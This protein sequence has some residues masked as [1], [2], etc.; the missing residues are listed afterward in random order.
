MQI[1][2]IIP[3]LNAGRHLEKLLHALWKQDNKPSEIIIIDSSSEDNT[4]SVAK[5]AGAKI[6][7]IPRHEFDH[8]RT[9]N[10]AAKEAKGDILIFMTQD[11]LPYDNELIT[12]LTEALRLPNVAAA[13]ARHIPRPGAPLLETFARR[14]NY[15]DKMTIKGKEDIT[16]YGIKTF[17]FSNVCSAIKK[18]AFLYAGMFKEGIRLNEDM[19]LSARLILNGCRVAY[20][21]EARV[22]HSHDY[23]LRQQLIR[24]YS[25]G[26]S[27][28]NNDWI[29][30]YVTAEGEGMRFIREQMRFVLEQ[31]RYS[32]IPYMILE[33][34]A[35]YAGYRIGR[36][37]G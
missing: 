21:P 27:L 30:R 9:R 12:R 36:L 16:S 4:A 26:A 19:L 6:L 35:K 14:F 33:S 3:T 29:L 18:E 31:R 22:L 37:A 2:V 13:Y 34:L 8:G 25:I 24:Y 7:L 10:M 5:G 11:A 23:S 32:L 17:F 28:R 20:A 1:S 15:P